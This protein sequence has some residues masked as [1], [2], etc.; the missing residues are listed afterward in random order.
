MDPQFIQ[1]LR[2]KLQRRVRRLNSV[3]ADLFVPAL[4]QFWVFFDSNPTYAGIAELLLAQF[5]EISTILESIKTGRAQVGDTEQESAAI[6]Y[7]V[8]RDL[9]ESNKH[10]AMYAR[11]Y[12]QFS[13]YDE[14]METLREVFLEPFYEY[15]DEQ[16]D[17]QRATL[18]LLLR[19]KHRCEWFQRPR[20]WEM[21]QSESRKAEK[22][23]ALDLY[24]YLYDQGID[25]NIEP[26]SLTGEVDLIGAQGTE[27]PLL[28]DAKVFDA[29][30]RG[31]TYIRK[32]FNQIYTY[33]Q[34]HNEPFGYLI[35]FKITDKDLRFSLSSPSRNIPVVV[36]NHKT[37]FL[38][39]VDIY[40]YSEPVSQRDP[41]RAIEITEEELIRP[42]E[43]I[44]TR[45]I[46]EAS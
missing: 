32:A 20:L 13:K 33:T 39:I 35:I 24:S 1:N 30:G 38:V 26:S 36:Y 41:L 15:V 43:G 7:S 18:S 9:A 23:L 14:A 6:G 12:R 34:Q 31:K 21:A 46:Q 45:A 10:F 3:D 40:S 8:L 5:P 4:K 2:Y 44:N 37:I 28:A 16:L 17:D 11:P 27:D 19:Y 29:E 22:L 42:V 25:F